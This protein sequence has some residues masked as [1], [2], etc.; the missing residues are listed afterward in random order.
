MAGDY[1]YHAYI[2]DHLTWEPLATD[3]FVFVKL[4]GADIPAPDRGWA[5]L[6]WDEAPAASDPPK[7]F[8]LLGNYPNPFNASTALRYQ[9]PASGFIKLQVYDTAGR[10][11]EVLVNGYRSAGSH[12]I[13]FDAAGL[14]SGIYVYRLRAGSS[15]A[16]G[17]MILLK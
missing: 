16:V 8:A 1:I 14:A 3:S 11:V 2:R 17:K 4:S 13:T 7:E 5:L 15:E 9:L 6:G 12:E 10:L